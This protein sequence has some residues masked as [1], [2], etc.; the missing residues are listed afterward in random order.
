MA[1]LDWTR[2]KFVDE[3]GVTLA[4]THLFGRAPVGERA[5]GSTPQ[6][7][8][9]NVTLLGALGVSGL[10]ALMSVAGPTE[11]D[12]FRVFIERVLGPTLQAGDIVVMGN[13][14]AH[15]VVGIRQAIEERGARLV[16]LPPYS[17]DFSPIEPCWSKLKTC[18][19]GL[20]ARTPRKLA[21]AIKKAL[22][23][24]TATD[25]CA[26]FAHCGYTVN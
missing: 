3:S 16:Y 19:R 11:G 6:N 8:G 18:W 15:K 12:V 13:L 9:Q 20:G 7:Y 24:I 14:G 1:A 4:L 22:G 26:W 23:T 5:V 2:L 17:P 25:A 21:R 10:Q